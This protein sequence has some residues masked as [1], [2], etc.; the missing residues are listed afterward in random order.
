MQD[1]IGIMDTWL[2][3]SHLNCAMWIE[4][5]QQRRQIDPT[6]FGCENN[7]D[8]EEQRKEQRQ[9]AVR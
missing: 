5:I 7:D 9:K 4:N 8:A 2:L 1:K 6:L 3:I